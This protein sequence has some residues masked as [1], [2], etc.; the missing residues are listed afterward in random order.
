MMTYC[1]EVLAECLPY[2][3]LGKMGSAY[4]KWTLN[5]ERTWNA[6]LAAK[7]P[8]AVLPI[9]MNKTYRML[10]GEYYGG[11]LEDKP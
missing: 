1:L 5:L 10:K 2:R 9:C 3:T 6:S 11:D 7:G 4:P 8:V